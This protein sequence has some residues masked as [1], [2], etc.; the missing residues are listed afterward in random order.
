MTAADSL[1]FRVHLPHWGWLALA[2]AVLVIAAIGLA[3]WIP[4]HREEQAI[5]I[6]WDLGGQVFI[7]PGGPDWFRSLEGDENIKVFDRVDGVD[8]SDTAVTNEDVRNVIARLK[9]LQ[10][11]R[12]LHLSGTQLTDAGLVHLT[13]LTNLEHLN[14]D[15][16][17][18]TDAGLVR[19]AELRRLKSLRLHGT[20]VTDEGVKTLNKALPECAIGH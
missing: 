9:E 8:L 3:I 4:F 1:R 7:A 17:H 19:L 12:A 10:H 11:L 15:N 14:L 2:T 5:H 20:Q 16:T 13:S 18:I 6:I